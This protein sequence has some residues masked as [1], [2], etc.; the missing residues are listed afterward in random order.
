MCT[1]IHDTEH[2]FSSPSQVPGK[3]NMNDF[4]NVSAALN[5]MQV[6][7]AASSNPSNRGSPRISG[8]PLAKSEDIDQHGYA[9]PRDNLV[10][11]EGSGS[12]P[13]PSGPPPPPPPAGNEYAQ[14]IELAAE[15]RHHSRPKHRERREQLAMQQGKDKQDRPK[16]Y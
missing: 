11:L 2:S 3:L 1:Y 7:P 16:D 10:G 6:D 4:H 12:M 13:P 8:A 5:T 14:P 15:R 9:V